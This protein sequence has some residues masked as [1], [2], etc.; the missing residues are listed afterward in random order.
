MTARR[1]GIK[2]TRVSGGQQ[3]IPRVLQ[4]AGAGSRR[5]RRRSSVRIPPVSRTI[6]LTEYEHDVVLV[7]QV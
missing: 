6:T 2:V 5:L 4:G 7:L 1:S 3:G